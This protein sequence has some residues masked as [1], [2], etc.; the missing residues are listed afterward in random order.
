MQQWGDANGFDT[1]LLGGN[2]RV[3]VLVPVTG[4]MWHD[5]YEVCRDKKQKYSHDGRHWRN[6]S[7]WNPTW[8][9]VCWFDIVLIRRESR[10]LLRMLL[11][12]GALSR[13]GRFC[14][15]LRNGWFPSWIHTL[16]PSNLK[17]AHK[18]LRP[19]HGQLC[20]HFVDGDSPQ[21]QQLLAR[22]AG[23]QAGGVGKGK[24]KGLGKMLPA[25]AKGKGR[26]VR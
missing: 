22:L 9:A 15:R 16:P 21:N 11:D 2:H 4:R 5:S 18:V 25:K 12:E 23:D 19:D 10:A 6:F 26:Q 3:P 13:H 1:F 24:G 14:E 7:A 8:S 20:D 17:C